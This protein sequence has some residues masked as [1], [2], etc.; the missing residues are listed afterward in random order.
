MVYAR[1]HACAGIRDFSR[2]REALRIGRHRADRA[3]PLCARLADITRTPV[4]L[5]NIGVGRASGL[6]LDVRR[7]SFDSLHAVLD[8]D[9]R[10]LLRD[11]DVPVAHLFN[12]TAQGGCPRTLHHARAWILTS[13]SL[14]PVC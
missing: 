4:R 11:A 5:R 9:L 3:K 13:R 12:W 6:A 10:L 8:A 14:L 2:G 1:L 7:G